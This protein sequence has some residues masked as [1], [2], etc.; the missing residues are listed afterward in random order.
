[1]N[2]SEMDA[3]ITK[4]AFDKYPN[5]VYAQQRFTNAVNKHFVDIID[6][7]KVN[8]AEVTTE[9]EWQQAYMKA[10][11]WLIRLQTQLKQG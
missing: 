10:R 8:F 4:A 7:T 5:N 2:T 9:G 3:A 11:E 6:Q 1:M